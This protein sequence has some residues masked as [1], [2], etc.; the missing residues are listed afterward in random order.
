[1]LIVCLLGAACNLFVVAPYFLLFPN[2]LNF[3]YWFEFTPISIVK[4]VELL[5]SSLFFRGKPG[6]TDSISKRESKEVTVF[7]SMR[8]LGKPSNRQTNRIKLTLFLTTEELSLVTKEKVSRALKWP[9]KFYFLWLRK[10]P[11]PLRTLEFDLIMLEFFKIALGRELGLRNPS[12]EIRS[13]TLGTKL[14]F[15][16]GLTVELP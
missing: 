6:D 8:V 2:G 5:R 15:P 7:C 13:V 11:V 14:E 1:M 4:E 12:L 3:P 9:I 16:E 10:L